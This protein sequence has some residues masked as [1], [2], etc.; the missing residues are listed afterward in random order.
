MCLGNM[1]M[2]KSHHRLRS[3]AAG[4]AN[5]TALDACVTISLTHRFHIE[6]W[7]LQNQTQLLAE[8]QLHDCAH[9]RDTVSVTKCEFQR[10]NTRRP[11]PAC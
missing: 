5:T 9:S 1:L 3:E 11:T 7:N 10:K 2:L 6:L 8:Q 4:S